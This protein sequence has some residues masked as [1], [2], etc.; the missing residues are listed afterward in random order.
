MTYRMIVSLPLVIISM[1][2]I[3]AQDVREKPENV[4]FFS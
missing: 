3:V 2:Y 1:N 4:Y